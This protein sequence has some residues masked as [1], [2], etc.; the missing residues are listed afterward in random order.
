MGGT[1]KARVGAG[2]GVGVKVDVGVGVGVTVDV[3][4]GVAVGVDVAVAVSVGVAV[5]LKAARTAWGASERAT[6][7]RT[8]PRVT[9]SSVSPTKRTFRRRLTGATLVGGCA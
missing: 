7:A 5:G 4:V 3:A 8:H 2:V 1:G 9:I 6:T